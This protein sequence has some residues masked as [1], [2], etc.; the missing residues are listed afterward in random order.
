MKKEQFERAKNSPDKGVLVHLVCNEA[1]CLFYSDEP[2]G[3]AEPHC[4]VLCVETFFSAVCDGGM[5]AWFDQ[6]H[7]QLAHR[8]PDAL[9]R[10]GMPAYAT[11][12]EAA[13]RCHCQ[14]ALPET[15]SAWDQQLARIRGQHG[16]EDCSE[17]YMPLDE[18][19]F[20][21]FQR[22]PGEFRERLFDYIIRHEADFVSPPEA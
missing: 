5:A 19:F 14:D 16:E 8:C 1:D 18:Q 15:V 13:L 9:R 20:D 6:D 3:L 2:D 22:H 10:V 7:G 4:T 12:A 11:L 21:L 17:I